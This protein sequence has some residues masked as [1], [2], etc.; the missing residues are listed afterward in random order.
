MM[1]LASVE[2]RVPYQHNAV[3]DLALSIGMERKINGRE[4]KILLKEAFRDRIPQEVIQR[5][6]RPFATPM[7][8]W[9]QVPWAAMRWN[10]FLRVQSPD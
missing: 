5:P 7:S 8:A 6:K 3:V 9:L 1:M 10:C 2:G 4:Q